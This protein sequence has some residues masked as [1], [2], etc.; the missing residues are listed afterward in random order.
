MLTTKSPEA[1]EWHFSQV[2]GERTPGEEILEG[3]CAPGMT[4]VLTPRH[5]FEF[6]L[7]RFLE[8]DRRSTP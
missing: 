1:L 3:M 5:S 6:I 2:F 8:V 4:L 7:N